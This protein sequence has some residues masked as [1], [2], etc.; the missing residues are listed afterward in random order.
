MFRGAQSNVDDPDGFAIRFIGGI[1]ALYGNAVGFKV[2][3]TYTK[4]NMPVTTET[5]MTTSTV[6]SSIIEVSQTVTAEQLGSNYLFLM[7]VNK[8]PYTV[9]TVNF[10]IVPFVEHGG[11]PCYG[12]TVYIT[13]QYADQKVTIK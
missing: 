6:Y 3:A 2:K 1:D 5:T 8:L 13:A 10:E 9:G 11:K 7:S 4:D 12:D